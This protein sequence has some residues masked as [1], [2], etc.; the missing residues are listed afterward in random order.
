MEFAEHILL[1]KKKA[2]SQMEQDRI[3]W[4]NSFVIKSLGWNTEDEHSV[5]CSGKVHDKIKNK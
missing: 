3:N 1:L 2:K 4:N 5:L